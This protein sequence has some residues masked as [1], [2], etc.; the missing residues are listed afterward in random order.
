MKEKTDERALALDFAP[1]DHQG[2]W[3]V[4]N[5]E[6]LALVLQRLHIT[7]QTVQ[8]IVDYVELGRIGL[9]SS[10]LHY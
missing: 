7:Q 9:W 2:S 4:V 10:H 6:S 3:T 8:V 1:D 5:L